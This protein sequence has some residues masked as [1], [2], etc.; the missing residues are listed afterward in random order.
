M[1]CKIVNAMAMFTMNFS[2]EMILL[3][4]V[5]DRFKQARDVSL[6]FGIDSCS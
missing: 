4:L 2:F 1:T 5:V 6:K 3:R